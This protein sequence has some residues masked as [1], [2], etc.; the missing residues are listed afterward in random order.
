[1][2]NVY[3]QSL[4]SMKRHLDSI[5]DDEFLKNYQA[6]EKH[7]GQSVSDYLFINSGTLSINRY[8]IEISSFDMKIQKHINILMKELD[9]DSTHNTDEDYLQNSAAA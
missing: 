6:I 8:K 3:D 7:C 5:S 2:N 1:M 4:A 9:Y